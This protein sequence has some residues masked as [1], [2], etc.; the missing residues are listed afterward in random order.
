MHVWGSWKTF[1]CQLWD[2]P[3]VYKM[4]PEG[5][6]SPGRFTRQEGPGV[7]LPVC[8][9]DGTRASCWSFC[10]GLVSSSRQL[11]HVPEDICTSG[12]MFPTGHSQAASWLWKCGHCSEACANHRYFRTV[13]DHCFSAQLWGSHLRHME[14]SVAPP[15]PSGWAGISPGTSRAGIGTW[16]KLPLL[17]S[18]PPLCP[19]GLSGRRS[20]PDPKPGRVVLGRQ[21]SGGR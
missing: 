13:G 5:R 2:S 20:R 16:V 10:S 15:P 21:H 11:L 17:C 12:F 3:A 19:T 8:S 7:Y 9:A 14:M 6:P 4:P 18:F 1:I